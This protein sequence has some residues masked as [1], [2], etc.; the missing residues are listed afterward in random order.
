MTPTCADCG[1]TDMTVVVHTDYATFCSTCVKSGGW[2][3]PPK[4][5][6][7][8]SSVRPAPVVAPHVAERPQRALWRLHDTDPG[9]GCHPVTKDAATGFQEAGWGIFWSVND[10]GG[11]PR[12]LDSLVQVLSWAIDVDGGDK[13]AQRRKFLGGPLVPS[14]LIETR[15]GHHAYWDAIDGTAANWN[16][17]VLGRLVPY[18]GADRNA[19][20]IARILRAPGYRHLKDPANPFP[21]RIVHQTPARYTEAQMLA[22]YPDAG[23]VERDQIERER[24]ERAAAR[25]EF[26]GGDGFWDRVHDLDC[27]L[28]LERLSGHPL[29]AGEHFTFRHAGSAGNLNIYVDGRG[30]SCWIDQNGRIGSRDKGGPGIYQW[31]R[32]YGASP[33]EIATVLK[34]VIPELERDA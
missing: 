22:A 4:V 20:D 3:T 7:T 28:A 31:L 33:R 19:R 34:Q 16:E 8:K 11:G 25:P 15:S 18:Y 5:I 13:D 32:W 1:R 12:R 10:F 17:V 24:A 23:R 27:R 2:Y 29:V 26:R 9:R 30:T 14:M 21:I 6:R